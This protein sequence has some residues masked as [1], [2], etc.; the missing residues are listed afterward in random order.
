MN[1]LETELEFFSPQ[2]H[3]IVLLI[4]LQSS[5]KMYLLNLCYGDF[6]CNLMLSYLI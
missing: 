1:Q 4:A 5:R 3:F 2:A 6:V